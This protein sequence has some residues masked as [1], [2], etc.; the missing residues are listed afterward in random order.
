MALRATP[1][2]DMPNK[3]RLAFTLSGKKQVDAVEAT[4]I[5]A[6]NMSDLVRGDYKNLTLETT[7]KLADYF[8][9]SIEDLFPSRAAV[10]S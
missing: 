2:G 5:A 7:R 9:C 10:A 1:L 3:L 8:G 6:P 4:G